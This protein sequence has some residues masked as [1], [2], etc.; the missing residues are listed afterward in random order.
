MPAS[1]SRE[2][3]YYEVALTNRQVMVAFSFLLVGLLVSFLSGVWV[4]KTTSPPAIE[5]AP[6]L[7]VVGEEP[8]AVTPDETVPGTA[9]AE[10]A[11]DS[12]PRLDY[13][14]GEGTV[15]ESEAAT[16][17]DTAEA[18]APA[19]TEVEPPA[20]ASPP[21]ASTAPVT[22]PP[23]AGPAAQ[24]APA[25][26]TP[27]VKPKWRQRREVAL[28]A[29]RLES[30]FASEEAEIEG[31]PSAPVTRPEPAAPLPPATVPA[32]PVARVPAT[33][34]T[35]TQF[36]VQV[37]SSKD[38][39]KAREILTSLQDA[40]YPASLSRSELAAGVT[41]R[42]RIGPYRDRPAAQ[43]VADDVSRRMKVDTWITTE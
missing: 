42:V 2:T 39:V 16:P 22:S 34:P 21:P 41:Y 35:G 4:G 28:E 43:K 29:E 10:A 31:A 25:A 40:G 1:E 9:P 6:P 24:P 38:A 7:R 19:P 23:P 11:A 26:D 36:L 33:K 32:P 20:A 15:A 30:E 3:S 13:F 27:L 8:A 18:L 12:P 17:G 14:E 5:E 37:F